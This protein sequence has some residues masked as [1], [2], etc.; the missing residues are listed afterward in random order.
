MVVREHARLVGMSILPAGSAP[1]APDEEDDDDDGAE[2]MTTSLPTAMEMTA[3][4][5]PV[6]LTAGQNA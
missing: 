5:E 4:E 1:D 3:R 2:T 6:L